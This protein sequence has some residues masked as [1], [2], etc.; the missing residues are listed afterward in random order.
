MKRPY[1]RLFPLLLSIL[2]ILPALAATLPAK[3][4]PGEV[5]DQSNDPPWLVSSQPSIPNS[6]FQSF[7]PTLP[8]LTSVD[9]R[10]LNDN[11]TSAYVMEVRIREGSFSG[12]ILGSAKFTVPPDHNETNTILIHVTFPYPIRLTPGSTYLIDLFWSS[13]T[14]AYRVWWTR[15]ADMYP[16]G[17]ALDATGNP[18]E[19]SDFNFQTWG[20]LSVGGEIIMT[21]AGS[22]AFVFFAAIAATATFLLGYGLTRKKR[23]SSF[24]SS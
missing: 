12:P 10:L 2:I 9:L 11:K 19:V 18:L 5:L 20:I 24:S 6:L 22:Y 1:L 21:P 13:E 17:Q 3:A 16:N 23:S 4:Y 14:N 8:F 7:K 15:G